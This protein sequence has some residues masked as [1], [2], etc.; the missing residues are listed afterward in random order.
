MTD[1]G[2]DPFGYGQV[3]TAASNDS[4]EDILFAGGGATAKAD[5]RDASWD[6]PSNA[7]ATEL[8]KIDFGAEV[9][10]E[11]AAAPARANSGVTRLM[12]SPAPAAQTK[13]VAA[14]AKAAA[15]ASANQAV[16]PTQR[17]PSGIAKVSQ[18]KPMPIRPIELPARKG[19]MMVPLLVVAAG[20]GAAAWLY[21]VRL[22]PVLAGIA[23]ALALALAGVA[24]IGLKR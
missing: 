19:A 5:P 23:G 3:R 16:V 24:W 17:A 8:G 21:Y 9:L 4:P 1:K 14:Q 22:N 15:A 7:A 12:G 6:P 2:Y 11:R 10:G 18:H 13:P 20:G